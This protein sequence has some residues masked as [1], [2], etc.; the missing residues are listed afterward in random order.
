M[1][2][3]PSTIVLPVESINSR[4]ASC[5]GSTPSI[6]C[7]NKYPSHKIPSSTDV[8]LKKERDSRRVDERFMRGVDYGYRVCRTERERM[9][10]ST[11]CSI[12]SVSNQVDERLLS[13]STLSV[14]SQYD[15][16]G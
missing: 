5:N 13:L 16:I 11:V 3:L 6:D 14:L 4:E 9:A 10:L 12:I 8:Q 1:G 7:S 15:I 2:V